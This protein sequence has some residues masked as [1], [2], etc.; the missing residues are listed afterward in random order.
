MEQALSK[1][2]VEKIIELTDEELKEHG[3]VNEIVRDDVF[4]VLDSHC[5]ILYYPLPEDDINGYHINRMINDKPQEFVF[6]N[7]ANTTEKQVFAAAH[8]LGHVLKVDEKIIKEFDLNSSTE[9]SEKIINRFAAEL[10]M[11]EKIFVDKANNIL[12][13]LNVK[14]KISIGNMLYLIVCLMNEFLVE[15]EAIVR[16]FNELKKISDDSRD[17][18]LKL[19]NIPYFYDEITSLAKASNFT[20]LFIRSNNR[21]IKNLKELVDKANEKQTLTET[22]IESILKTFGIKQVE[23]KDGH[24]PEGNGDSIDIL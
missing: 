23:I 24:N 11:P 19:K 17:L 18:L 3:I 6:I 20:R 12:K 16:R 8:E 1:E 21:S 4:S 10:L 15:F 14:D 13:T 2:I 5:L 22:K 7:T 9:L